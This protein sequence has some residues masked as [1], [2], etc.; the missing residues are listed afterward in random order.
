M[1]AIARTLSYNLKVGHV[2]KSPKYAPLKSYVAR[3]YED[4]IEM[5][6]PGNEASPKVEQVFEEPI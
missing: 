5:L 4:E 1:I 2:P 3:G 6:S